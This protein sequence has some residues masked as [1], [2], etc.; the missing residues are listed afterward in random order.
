MRSYSDTLRKQVPA[1]AATISS[2]T[3]ADDAELARARAFLTRLMAGTPWAE[4]TLLSKGAAVVGY[5][6]CGVVMAGVITSFVGFGLL[7]I[8][9]VAFDVGGPTCRTACEH[10]WFAWIIRTSFY[11]GLTAATCV[12]AWRVSWG[13]REVARLRSLSH[14]EFLREYRGWRVRRDAAEAMA[15]RQ[16]ELDYLARQTAYWSDFYAQRDR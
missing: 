10:A 6:L 2:S 9:V 3:S 12:V 11:G 8:A 14:D 5:T 13:E 16:D 15:Q 4:R 7:L 1:T